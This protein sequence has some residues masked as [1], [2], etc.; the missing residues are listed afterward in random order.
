ML[1]CFLNYLREHSRPILHVWCF[2]GKCI[3]EH[4]CI[5]FTYMYF[6]YSPP[7]NKTRTLDVLLS[8]TPTFIS[9]H[10]QSTE[11]KVYIAIFSRGATFH[12]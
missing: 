2:P 7:G 8:T 3:N 6:T 1:T 11:L 5:Y 4:Y 9:L 10:T 12:L